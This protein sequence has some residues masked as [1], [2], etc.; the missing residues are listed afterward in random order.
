MDDILGTLDSDGAVQ[1]WPKLNIMGGSYTPPAS[2]VIVG[3]GQFVV[4]PAG[5]TAWERVEEVKAAL[6]V[7]P[8]TRA[9]AGKAEETS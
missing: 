5:F 7:K 1:V 9:K 8:T 3:A 6:G 2:R 4:L